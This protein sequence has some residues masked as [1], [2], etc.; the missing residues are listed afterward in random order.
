[1]TDEEKLKD[2]ERLDIIEEKWSQ[3]S[4]FLY[5]N[6]MAWLRMRFQELQ[7]Q[8]EKLV[9]ALMK[10]AKQGP[11]DILLGRQIAVDALREYGVEV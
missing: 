11:P 9:I 6:D 5:K 1:M 4:I 8:N 7:A 2:N 10:Y 3:K